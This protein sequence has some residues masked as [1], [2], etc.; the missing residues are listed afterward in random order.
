MGL[1][2]SQH[3]LQF[4]KIR[5]EHDRIYQ[6]MAI[7]SARE[8]GSIESYSA[9]DLQMK[10]GKHDLQMLQKTRIGGDFC[11]V[12]T[13]SEPASRYFKDMCE[14]LTPERLADIEQLAGIAGL[15]GISK[16]KLKARVA[17]IVGT[18]KSHVAVGAKLAL[19]VHKR[20]AALQSEPP[21]DGPQLR[22]LEYLRAAAPYKTAA[23]LWPCI[24]KRLDQ[25][26]ETIEDFLPVFKAAVIELARIVGL[27]MDRLE[28]AEELKDPIRWFASR[29]AGLA[30]ARCYSVLSVAAPPPVQCCLFRCELRCTRLPP[31]FHSVFMSVYTGMR[32]RS[33]T[34]FTTSTIGTTRW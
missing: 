4:S 32:R 5:K 8:R 17:T 6:E 2:F 7:P 34:T 23:D 16:D 1:A 31:V 22:A 21:R 9:P 33:T 28:F 24:V 13:Q 27:K 26:Y 11:T 30:M 3:L 29:P 18:K 25:I 12:S 19:L 10:N 15:A 20:R 14:V